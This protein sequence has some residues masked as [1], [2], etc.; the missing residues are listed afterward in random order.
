M[1][2]STSPS[3]YQDGKTGR[4]GMLLLLTSL[5]ISYLLAAY[6]SLWINPEV[7]FWKEAYK[8]KIAW[9][10]KLTAEGRQKLVFIG[11]SGTAFQID[12]GIL[13]RAS[14]PA[15]NM[16]MHAGMGSR[17]TAALGLSA[18]AKGDTVIW[19]F[20]PDRLTKTPELEPLG[21]Q[22]LL[23]TGVILGKGP[24]QLALE[25]LH[26]LDFLA[27]LRPGLDHSAVMLAKV[28]LKHPLYRYKEEFIRP[29]GAITT[30]ELR[31]IPYSQV[32][33]TIPDSTTLAWISSMSRKLYQLDCNS[34]YLM[35]LTYSP[36]E[37]AAAILMENRLFL[38]QL[39]AGT[40][41]LSDPMMGVETNLQSFA[42][43]PMHLRAESMEKRTRDLIPILL[44][45]R[46]SP[47][48]TPGY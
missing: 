40:S 16:G 42:D 48:D 31:S 11:G 45:F 17:A 29:G 10:R 26:M 28:A 33:K 9:S 23:A 44:L 21:Y 41:V 14:I 12:A 43:T 38:K 37:N 7:R 15:V 1:N 24:E 4:G 34:A 3:S 47:K 35:P 2:L 8:R 19:A 22:I 36:P 32:H 20:E 5:V 27:A 25:N 30:D 39:S 13:T 6:Y 46:K 18:L